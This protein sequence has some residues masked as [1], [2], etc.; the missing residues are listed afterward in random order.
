MVNVPMMHC[1]RNEMMVI[2][3][4]NA[5]YVKI[6]KFSKCKLQS[7]PN[8][9]RFVICQTQ[10]NTIYWNPME[11]DSTGWNWQTIIF[12]AYGLSIHSRSFHPTNQLQ[13]HA[14]FDE[15]IYQTFTNIGAPYLPPKFTNK[16]KK[17]Q[18]KS[19]LQIFWCI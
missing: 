3:L 12:N 19:L 4:C 11:N 2:C 5:L 17:L 7:V 18:N 6:D 16:H 8:N 14:F 13:L 9:Y 10:V 15:A 1:K